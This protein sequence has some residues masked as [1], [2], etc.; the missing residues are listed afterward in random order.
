ME[1]SLRSEGGGG[2]VAHPQAAGTLS[3]QG[4]GWRS[5]WVQASREACRGPD[6]QRFIRPDCPWAQ[7]QPLVCSLNLGLF[8]AQRGLEIFLGEMALLTA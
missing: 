8:M 7:G 2:P 5:V 3:R 1:A 4:L 6:C